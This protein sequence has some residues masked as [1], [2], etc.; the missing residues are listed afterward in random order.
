MKVT[1]N[2]S[3]RT[4][5]KK[6]SESYWPPPSEIV[7]IEC[8]PKGTVIK[9]NVYENTNNNLKN[10]TIYLRKFCFCLARKA[11][12]IQEIYL[13]VPTC[14]CYLFLKK[15]L[16]WGNFSSQGDFKIVVES[17]FTELLKYFFFFTKR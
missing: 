8:M 11:R 15:H 5:P 4:P 13:T 2:G 10:F 3:I 7:L 12:I 14:E 9:E 6:A 1:Y 16:R 17:Y